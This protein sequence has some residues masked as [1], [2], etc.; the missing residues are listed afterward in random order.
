MLMSYIQF[1]TLAGSWINKCVAR[2]YALHAHLRRIH[3]IRLS[4]YSVF[5]CVALQPEVHTNDLDACC[6]TG[7][8]KISITELQCASKLLYYNNPLLVTKQRRNSCY[9]LSLKSIL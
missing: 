7:I 9:M 2:L 5:A 6:K 4:E 3:N 8:E 1:P